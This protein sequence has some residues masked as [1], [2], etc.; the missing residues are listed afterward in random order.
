MIKVEN[1]EKHFGTKRAVAGITFSLERGEILGFL[2]QGSVV[3]RAAR[4]ARTEW[5]QR[6]HSYRQMGTPTAASGCAPRRLT[7]ESRPPWP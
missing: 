7:S 6:D 5:S 3:T 1:L 4:S 2:G